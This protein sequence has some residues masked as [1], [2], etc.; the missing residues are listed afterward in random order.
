MFNVIYRIFIKAQFAVCTKQPPVLQ[1]IRTVIFPFPANIFTSY[2]YRIFRKYRRVSIVVKSRI[3]VVGID[4]V[5]V[6]N[7][8]WMLRRWPLIL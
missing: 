4:D 8:V 3:L 6:E 2:L 5:D 1:P 7:S